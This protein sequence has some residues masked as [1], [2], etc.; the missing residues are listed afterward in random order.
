MSEYSQAS[1]AV[2]TKSENTIAGRLREHAAASNTT[3]VPI[4]SQFVDYIQCVEDNK[5]TYCLDREFVTEEHL[6]PKSKDIPIKQDEY[7]AGVYFPRKKT[8]QI[9]IER[10]PAIKNLINEL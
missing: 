9:D 6:K 2:L 5:G 10:F 3:V 4:R 1:S 8:N 7:K